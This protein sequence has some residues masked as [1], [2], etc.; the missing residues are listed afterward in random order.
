MAQVFAGGT[1]EIISQIL[2]E[3]C[4]KKKIMNQVQDLVKYCNACYGDIENQF[5]RKI[6]PIR[7]EE[8]MREPENESITQERHRRLQETLAGNH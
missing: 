8:R 6:R 2:V 5:H 3:G 7:V 4:D 1:R